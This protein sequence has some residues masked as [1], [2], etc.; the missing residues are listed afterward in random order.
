MDDTINALLPNQ[1]DDRMSRT[2]Y[3]MDQQKMEDACSEVLGGRGLTG[4]EI[5][6]LNNLYH[7]L[8]GSDIST[9][10]PAAGAEYRR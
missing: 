10:W 6:A 2:A 3:F 5:S 1:C 9:S 8:A 4:D 7:T